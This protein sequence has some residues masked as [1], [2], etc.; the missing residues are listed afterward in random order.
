MITFISS[1]TT[2]KN[3]LNLVLYISISIV[4]SCAIYEFSYKSLWYAKF[5]NPKLIINQVQ[6]IC[7]NFETFARDSNLRVSLCRILIGSQ[8]Q[9]IKYTQ[10]YNEHKKL[11]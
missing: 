6:C 9:E 5:D 11:G 2:T 8:N 10:V 4:Y 3:F 1:F 7:C